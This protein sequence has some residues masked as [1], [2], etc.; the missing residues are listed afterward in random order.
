MNTYLHQFLNF[1]DIVS[2]VLIVQ[3]IILSVIY[4]H[5]GNVPKSVFW[6][7]IFILTIGILFM[8]KK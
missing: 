5:W 8:G 4:F 1:P 6:F 7:G 3:Y 2:M